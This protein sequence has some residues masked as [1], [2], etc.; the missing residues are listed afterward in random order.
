MFFLLFYYSYNR[1]TALKKQNPSLKIIL[2]LG[3]WNAKST[4]F[5]KIAATDATMNEFNVKALAF[6]REHNFDGLDIDWEYPTDRD[7]N[8]EDKQRFTLWLQVCVSLTCD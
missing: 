1:T 8:P 6:L 3:G 7:G 2:A 4:D 5:T